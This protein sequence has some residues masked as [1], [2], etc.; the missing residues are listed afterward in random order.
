M[1]PA[2]PP[3]GRRRLDHPFCHSGER[4]PSSAGLL[5][6]CQEFALIDVDKASNAVLA[7]TTIPAPVHEPGT[8]SRVACR[9]RSQLH[10]RRGN[11][12]AG[13][14]VVRGT[15]R[16]RGYRS[17]NGRAGDRRCSSIW[18]GSLVTG[19]NV[20]GS[21]DATGMTVGEAYQLDDVDIMNALGGLPEFPSSTAR[22]TQRPPCM[23]L[24]T[25]SSSVA[26]RRKR[27]RD[28]T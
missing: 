17:R 5:G 16:D 21:L 14:A 6:H 13:S 28:R 7:T 27:G 19:D 9:P 23:R 24:S 4:R 3:R 18:A 11:G 26:S 12:L 2:A 20:C 22:I 8:A 10:H 15:R 25:I 1:A